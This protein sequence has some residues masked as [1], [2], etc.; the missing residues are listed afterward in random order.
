M[1][2]QGGHGHEVMTLNR[3]MKGAVG[4]A[5]SDRFDRWRGNLQAG[6]GT[7]WARTSVRRWGV[8]W[9]G[10]ACR[11]VVGLEKWEGRSWR[12]EKCTCCEPVIPTG[13][14]YALDDQ[15][16][17]TAGSR[18]SRWHWSWSRGCAQGVQ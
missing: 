2:G 9:S 14:T 3:G 10:E 4:M 15:M 18:R 8:C 11:L 16:C 6:A 7:G 17:A 13:C 5:C 12:K 1:V